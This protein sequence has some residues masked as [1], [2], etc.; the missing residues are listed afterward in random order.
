ME[1]G[2]QPP[3]SQP[4]PAPGQAP[5]STPP[6]PPSPAP[7][8]TSSP[9]PPPPAPAAAAQPATAAPVPLDTDDT[10]GLHLRRLGTHPVT[11][12]LG[13]VA[14]IGGFV[15]GT[16]G[17]GAAIGAAVAVG[18]ALVVLLIVFVLASNAAKDDFFAS[19]ADIRGLQRT[20]GKSSLPPTTPLLR[21]GDRRYAEELMNGTLPGGAAGALAL[22]TY[23][24]ETTD[25]DGDRDTDYH[26]YT[27]VLHE[28]P[29][30]A[31]RV[32][33]INCQRRSGFRFLDGAE[34]I[35]RR[36]HRLELES[37]VLDKNFEIFYGA[38]DDEN[39][40]KQ[41]FSPTFIVWMTERTPDGMAWELSAGALCVYVRGHYDSA[42]ELDAICAAA[43]E[44]ASR[45]VAEASE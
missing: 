37:E 36:M 31:A 23:E 45:L 24:V 11:L 19:Y 43:G 38:D 15:G 17:A 26:R 13:S 39:W 14:V 27:V 44:V 25:S 41:L 29:S 33:D 4:P 3:P 34:D 12:S 28:V 22:Y 8:S 1:R 21:K 40:L 2:S 35:F 5:A 42:A 7:A 10:R 20:S 30:V 16:L 9:Q 18:M 6:P 32:A